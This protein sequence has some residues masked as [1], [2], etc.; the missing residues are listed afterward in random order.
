VRGLGLQGEA[1]KFILP[2]YYLI[3]LPLGLFFAFGLGLEVRGLWLAAMISVTIQCCIFLRVILRANWQEIADRSGEVM[4][5][6]RDNYKQQL[7]N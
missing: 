1:A 2:A 4:Q 3:G 6:F 5:E 7:T